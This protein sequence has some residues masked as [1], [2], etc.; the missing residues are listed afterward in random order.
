MNTPAD[1]GDGAPARTRSRSAARFRRSLTP[2]RVIALVIAA[3]VTV[4][5]VLGPLLV[6]FDPLDTG[7]GARFAPPG[8]AGHLLGTD[9]FG[10]DVATRLVHGLRT[11]LVIALSATV[12]AAA[13]G[14]VLGVLGGYFGRWVE[15]VTMRVTD[16]VLAFPTIVFA[17]LAV[18]VFG[19]GTVTLI[20]VLAVLFAPTYAR[21]AY[22]Q[23]LSV[24]RAEY[25]E[26]EIAFGSPTPRLL[27]R[28]VLPNVLAPILVQ[29]SLTVA[30]AVLLESGLSFLGLGVLPPAPSL[31]LMIADGQRYL[32]SEPG[33]LLVPATAVVLTILAFGALGD[34]LRDWLDPRR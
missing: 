17:L 31:G 33:Q 28:T 26:A 25:V 18:A 22:G 16:V 4:A 10:R 8:T 30:A 34:V 27:R 9:A 2:W 11:E 14:T 29:L 20:L 12:L 5:A 13:A 15:L 3:L 19:A 21:L 24:R 23:V 7:T 32:S 6:P 1:V